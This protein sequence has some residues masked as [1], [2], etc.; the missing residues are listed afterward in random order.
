MT[1]SGDAVRASLFSP[2]ETGFN[3]LSCSWWKD[4]FTIMTLWLHLTAVL[5][6]QFGII[7]SDLYDHL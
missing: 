1:P 7:A 5:L 4:D 6:K 2:R 3:D